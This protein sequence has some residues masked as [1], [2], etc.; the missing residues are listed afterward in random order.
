MSLRDGLEL[1]SGGHPDQ[2]ALRRRHDRPPQLFL[3]ERVRDRGRSPV[4]ADCRRTGLHHL[5][6]ARSGVAVTLAEGLPAENDAP[7]AEHDRE[8]VWRVRDALMDGADRVRERTGDDIVVGE[9][10]DRRD[11]GVRALD[12]QPV[13]EPVGLPGVVVV[14]LG[15]AE[16]FEPARG[17]WAQVSEMLVSRSL[18]TKSGSIR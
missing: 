11:F 1:G 9:R 6:D 13:C 7:L 18:P 15:E 10:A 4:R 5:L 14:D 2:L 3:R 16:C 12:R 8:R 17:S